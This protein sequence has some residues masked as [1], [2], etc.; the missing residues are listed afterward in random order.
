MRFATVKLLSLP[1]NVPNGYDY[2]VPD[3]CFVGAFV[4][5]PI[6]S[7]NKVTFGVVTAIHE[8]TDSDITYKQVDY[9]YKREYSL[10]PVMLGLAEYIEET[11]LCS[12]GDAVRAV[13]PTAILG[14]LNE[15]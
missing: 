5:V 12:F 13:F 3:D 7:S 6:G 8:E 2:I 15:Y 10:T 11:T 14:T 9:I 4:T 1:F